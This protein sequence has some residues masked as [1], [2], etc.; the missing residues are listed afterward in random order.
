MA[1]EPEVQK[2][3]PQAPSLV[4]EELA[5]PG[6]RVRRCRVPGGWFVTVGSLSSFFYPDPLGV[7]DARL[8]E[9]R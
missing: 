6:Q 1:K 9:K 3:M 5:D 7:W 2:P 8:K 4:W